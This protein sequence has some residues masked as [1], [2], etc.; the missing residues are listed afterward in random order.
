[1]VLAAGNWLERKTTQ[2]LLEFTKAVSDSEAL[3]ELV[4]RR[5]LDRQFHTLFDWKTGTVSTFVSLFGSPTKSLVDA[6]L[7]SN[8]SL[9]Q[10]S[11]DF[12]ALV[13]QRNLLAHDGAISEEPQFT[14][15]QVRSMFYNAASWVSWMGE[16]LINGAAPAWSP[17]KPPGE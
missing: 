13:H 11:R 15:N 8:A 6:A 17:E 3:V 7:R 14:A 12:M 2:E 4:K 5:V 9:E 10:A 16:T 1:M